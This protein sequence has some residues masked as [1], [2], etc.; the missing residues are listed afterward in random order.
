L[1]TRIDYWQSTV[2]RKKPKKREKIIYYKKNL[3]NSQKMAFLTHAHAPLVT[4]TA[5]YMQPKAKII[6]L[7]SNFSEVLDCAG[8]KKIILHELL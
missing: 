4:K 5:T 6:R 1:L 7:S 2:C 8:I 3:K